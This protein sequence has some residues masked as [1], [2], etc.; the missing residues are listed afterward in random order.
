MVPSLPSPARPYT[1]EEIVFAKCNEL[2]AT[3]PADYLEV[4]ILVV[5]YVCM[6]VCMY[7]WQSPKYMYLRMYECIHVCVL[8]CMRVAFPL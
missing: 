2:S 7:V 8:V 4:K 1:V 5:M 3:M 6:Y